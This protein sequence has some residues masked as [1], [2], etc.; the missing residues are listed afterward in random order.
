M[1][2][3]R[4][5]PVFAF[6]DRFWDIDRRL[7][8]AAM[9][10]FENVSKTY[11]RGAHKALDGVSL[12]IPRG[13][14]FGLLGPNGSGK[15]TLLSILVGLVRRDS[16]SVQVDGMDVDRDLP[17][18]KSIVG[19]VP[20]TLAL[21][22]MLSVRENLA[23]YAGVCGIPRAAF[24]ERLSEVL[25]IAGLRRNLDDRAEALS[26][27]M[28]RRLNLAIGLLDRPR[29][30]CLDEPTVGIDPQSRALILDSIAKLNTEGVTVVYTS[31]YMNEVERICDR[32][33]IIDQGKILVVGSLAEL[34]QEDP[35]AR[36]V[37]FLFNR[38]A[39]PRVVQDLKSR[40]GAEFP[41]VRVMRIKSEDPISAIDAVIAL[42]RAQSAAEVV[43][44]QFGHRNL[45]ELFLALTRRN[46]SDDA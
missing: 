6:V 27:G 26:G 12:H 4:A 18:I 39:E 35:A 10:K 8:A 31:H 14:V 30:L 23:F 13:S 21:Y 5:R 33:A 7:G 2:T 38:P 32:I 19:F 37:L 40:F 29:L 25:E 24:A 46:L 45:E 41:D 20:Q 36:Q 17:A 28:Q 34:L 11:A 9:I 15:T 44:I 3:P 16:G 1:A 43:S 22:P 42:M